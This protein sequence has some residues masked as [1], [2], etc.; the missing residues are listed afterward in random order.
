MKN[1]GLRRSLLGRLLF[2]ILALPPLSFALFFAIDLVPEGDSGFD[3][4]PG[5]SQ[6]EVDRLRHLRGLDRSSLDRYRCWLLGTPATGCAWW[7]GGNGVLRGD[8]GVSAR[9]GRPI[10]DLVRERLPRTLGIMLPAF[11]GGLF[12]AVLLGSGAAARPGGALDRTLSTLAFIG[13]G[14]PLHWLGLLA[15]LVLSL[16]FELLPSSGVGWGGL[17]SLRHAV[18]PVSVTALYFTGRW[19]RFVRAAVVDAARAPFVLGLR[20]RGVEG[21]R[22]VARV[23]RNAMVP[24]VSVAGHAL[25]SL[26]GGAAVIE[27][28]FVYPGMGT[29]LV[30][31]VQEKDHLTAMVLLLAYSAL[32]LLSAA[33]IDVVLFGLD[34]RLREVSMGEDVG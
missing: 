24:I 33:L 8:W 26:F 16:R 1:A 31:S 20:A 13:N 23:A 22:L 34:P 17:D 2:P 28:V 30:E 15:V 12:L 7:P 4:R 6:T 21:P 3:L 32:T 5:L 27:R 11:V 18:L 25:P 9:H 10:A 14:I 19:L 29:L